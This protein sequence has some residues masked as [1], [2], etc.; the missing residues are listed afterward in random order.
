[1]MGQVSVVLTGSVQPGP[2][3]YSRLDREFREKGWSDRIHLAVG[4]PKP[5]REM[6]FPS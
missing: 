4:V 2:H 5:V 6:G 1:M 3:G